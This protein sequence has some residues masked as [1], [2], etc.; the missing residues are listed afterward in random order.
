MTPCHESKT[1]VSERGLE[2]LS[3]Y[4]NNNNNP[5]RTQS[6]K[7]NKYLYSSNFPAPLN[8]LICFCVQVLICRNYKGDV[9]MAEIDHFMPLLMQ[10]EDE[11][12][13]CPVMSHGNVHF[14]WI[15]HSNLYRILHPL[16]FYGD[17][18]NFQLR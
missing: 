12:L 7:E 1:N 10:H 16:L 13:T 4:N 15:K 17:H 11:G 3:S 6:K 9:D 14:M 5:Q 18:R 2:H 8:H